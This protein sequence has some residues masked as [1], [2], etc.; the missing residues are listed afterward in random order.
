MSIH[1]SQTTASDA[2]VRFVN[3]AELC[4]ALNLSA[5]ALGRV[6]PA[7]E[8]AGFPARDPVLNKWFWPEVRSFLFRRH[9]IVDTM[10]GVDHDEQED[11]S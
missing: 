3:K 7:W 2:E 4:T 6:M 8:R 11:W 1:Q 9:G 5:K 10:S